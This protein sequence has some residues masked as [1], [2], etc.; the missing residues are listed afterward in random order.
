V[1][2]FGSVIFWSNMPNTM[3][4]SFL[5]DRSVGAKGDSL[6]ERAEGARPRFEIVWVALYSVL[7]FLLMLA[8][9][10]VPA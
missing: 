4:S 2:Y 1:R 8:W 6:I 5:I 3:R 7:A 10:D 9:I